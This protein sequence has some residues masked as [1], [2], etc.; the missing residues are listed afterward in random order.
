MGEIN[1]GHRG[2]GLKRERIPGEAGV[3]THMSPIRC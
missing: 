1:E 2:R 3:L